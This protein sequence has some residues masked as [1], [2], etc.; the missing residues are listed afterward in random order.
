MVLGDIT[1][2]LRFRQGLL[3]ID[4]LTDR[5]EIG[6]TYGN[7]NRLGWSWVGGVVTAR[8]VTNA[9]VIFLIQEAANAQYVIAQAREAGL[10]C[11]VQISAY[12]SCC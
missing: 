8:R 3:A 9:G 1:G 10:I 7:A 5:D 2:A 11:G 6:S 4:G 12:Y